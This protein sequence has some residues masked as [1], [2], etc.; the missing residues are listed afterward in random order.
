MVMRQDA[1]LSPQR[2]RVVPTWTL[3]LR[4]A[5][6]LGQVALAK[7]AALLK[8]EQLPNVDGRLCPSQFR[9]S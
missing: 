5:R 6:A 2:L 8:P 1:E 7:L 9:T 4:A 3:P